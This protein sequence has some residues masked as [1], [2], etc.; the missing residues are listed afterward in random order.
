MMRV[1]AGGDG[2]VD[3][4]ELAGLVVKRAVR[5]ADADHHGVEAALSA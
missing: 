2:I 1:R 4:V 5:Q 3:E